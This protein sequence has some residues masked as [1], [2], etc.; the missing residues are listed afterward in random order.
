MSV[1][2]RLVM[3]GG[4]AFCR[5]ALNWVEN[6]R[7][8]QEL[9]QKIFFIAS[10]PKVI[11]QNKYLVDYLG[12]IEDFEPRETD[13]FVMTISEPKPKREFSQMLRSRGARFLTLVHPTVV[14]AR[15]ATIGEGVV[16]CPHAMISADAVVGDLVTINTMSSVGHDVSLGSYSTL[17]SHVDLTGY[18]KVGEACFFGSGARVL[19]KVKVGEGSTIGAGAVVMRSVSENCVMYAPPA[20]KL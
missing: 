13:L 17:S 12:T 2:S 3:V 9:P 11:D 10:D 14:I 5:E 16:V 18:V 15:T 8:K 20:R 4:G 1:N 19:P 6:S 7:V